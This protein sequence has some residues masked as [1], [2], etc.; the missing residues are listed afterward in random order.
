MPLDFIPCALLILC[1]LPC[2]PPLSLCTPQALM[3]LLRRRCS[4][5]VRLDLRGNAIGLPGA[6]LL[7]GALQEGRGGALAVLALSGNALEPDTCQV[8]GWVGWG[9]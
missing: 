3:P 7:G 5:L 2:I 6:L 4:A 1:L 8:S 9:M